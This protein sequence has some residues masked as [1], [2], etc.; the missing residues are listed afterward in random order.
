VNTVPSKGASRGRATLWG[1]PS[2]RGGE[3][4]PGAF[5]IALHIGPRT[6][7]WAKRGL[8]ARTRPPLSSRARA[9]LPPAPSWDPLVAPPA[10]S[11]NWKRGTGRHTKK[12]TS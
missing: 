6:A 8:G 3:R 1:D 12:Q 7:R 9:S 10:S 4:G 5:A 2:G 11:R